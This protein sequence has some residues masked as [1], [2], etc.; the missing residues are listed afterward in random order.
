[1]GLYMHLYCNSKQLT[2]EVNSLMYPKEVDGRHEYAVEWF[3]RRGTI[4]YWCNAYAIHNWFVKNVQYDNDDCGTY[5]VEPD[6]LTELL[7]ACE[8]VLG[9]HSLAEK[10]LPIRGRSCFGEGEYDERYFEQL[11]YTA[12]AIRRILGRIEPAEEGSW[13]YVLDG[14]PDWYVTFQYRSS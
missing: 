4:M 14:D 13:H 5:D 1:M 11:E 2:W 8:S 7:E 10:L 12:S 6:R 9:D 3:S